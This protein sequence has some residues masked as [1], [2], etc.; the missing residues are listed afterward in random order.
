MARRF[1]GNRRDLESSRG[2]K[3]WRG[4]SVVP[5][6]VERP[7]GAR[8][9]MAEV[10]EKPISRVEAADEVLATNWREGAEYE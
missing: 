4:W 1:G 7:W 10:T 9:V 8:H 5:V 6:A 3:L 2:T